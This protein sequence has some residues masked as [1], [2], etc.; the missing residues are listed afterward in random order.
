MNSNAGRIAKKLARR[1]RRIGIGVRIAP[2]PL[3]HQLAGGSSA[4][5]DT[6]ADV[7][8]SFGAPSGDLEAI[9][10]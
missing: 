2:E 7:S 6:L 3:P 10:E 4:S 5:T 1:K 8:D 9:S